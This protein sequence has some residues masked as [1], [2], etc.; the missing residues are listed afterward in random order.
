M[1]RLSRRS[2][3]HGALVT[4]FFARARFT[5]AQSPLSVVATF[6]ILGDMTANVAGSM[7]DL[8]VIVGPDGDTHTFEPRPEQI[9]WIADAAVIIEN[10][11]GFEPWLD[12][13]SSDESGRTATRFAGVATSGVPAVGVTVIR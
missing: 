6:S 3:I 13:M 1:P 11:L 7:L 4:P 5:Q 10:G 9:G 12:D 8:N 2:V